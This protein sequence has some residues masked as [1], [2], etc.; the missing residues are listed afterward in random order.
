MDAAPCSCSSSHG[1]NGCTHTQSQGQWQQQGPQYPSQTVLQL[2]GPSASTVPAFAT[3]YIHFP[4]SQ[5]GIDV[6]N[7][8]HNHHN[9]KVGCVA[10]LVQ[11]TSDALVLA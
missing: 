2:T 4:T 6:F 8:S 1:P 9:C 11:T 5:P 7:A 3:S 10:G